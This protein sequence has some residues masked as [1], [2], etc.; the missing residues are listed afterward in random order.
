MKQISYYVLKNVLVF[1][2]S[3][4]LEKK[5][6]KICFIVSHWGGSIAQDDLLVS[7]RLQPISYISDRYARWLFVPEQSCC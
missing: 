7:Y 4:I 3:G 5:I 6:I 2:D 1:L